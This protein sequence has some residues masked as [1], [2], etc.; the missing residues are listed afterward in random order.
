MKLSDRLLSHGCSL[1][2]AGMDAAF[3]PRLSILIFHR[4]LP[5]ADPIFPAELDAP[6]FDRLMALIARTFRVMPL[7]A[8]VAGLARGVLPQRAMCI[9]FDD[10]Y[11]DNHDIALPILR[12][13]GLT[14]CFFVATGF[15]DG[16]RM[17][18]DTVIECVRRSTLSSVDLSEFGLG[19]IPLSRASDRADTI[20]KLL[21]VVKFRSLDE[22]RPL[23]D[24]LQQLLRPTNLPD[25][26]MLTRPQVQQLRA[27]GMEI[28]AHTVMHPILCKLADAA[29]EQELADSQSTLAALLDEPIR[30]LAYPNGL[31]D[32]DYD[33]RHVAMARKLGFDAAVTTACGTAG[34]G[35]DAH[36]LPRYTPWSPQPWRWLPKLANARRAASYRRA[37]QPPR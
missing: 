18:N 32:R 27:A 37:S 11:A 25:D 4:V 14:A 35:A 31:P 36:Q 29:A 15:L 17:F 28:G 9:T 6:R 20:A 16:G 24:R 12:K 7:G 34:P 2:T 33:M 26:L 1:A 3:G 30:L 23:L 10:G 21:P 13:H 5:Q 22:R 19:R 8:A